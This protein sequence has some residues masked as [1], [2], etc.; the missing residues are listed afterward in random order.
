MGEIPD[1]SWFRDADLQ[2]PLSPY[3][4]IVLAVKRGSVSDFDQ[5]RVKNIDGF[6]ADGLLSLVTRL[7]HSV[8]K[9]GLRNINVSYSRISFAD[10]AE[11]LLMTS[12]S[13]AEFVCAKAIRDGVIDATI[14]HDNG[15]LISSERSD[16]YDTLEPQ[17][18]FHRRI[19]FCISVHND[20]VKS[21]SYPA[22]AHKPHANGDGTES[23]EM[24]EDI[25][26]QLQAA[27]DED[28][29]MY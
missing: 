9:T 1:R 15:I 16:V 5:A 18:A 19:Q 7:K 14:D 22:N 26:E 20:A 3:F 27:L 10:I 8:I 2:G 12:G 6:R 11:R 17:E 25:V 28:D 24:V 29:D 4:D 13:A 23:D 21:M